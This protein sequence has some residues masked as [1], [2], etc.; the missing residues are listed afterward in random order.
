[1]GQQMSMDDPRRVLVVD[2]HVGVR[3]GIASLI[4]GEHPRLLTV[5][6][7]ATPERRCD[8]PSNSSR[9]WWCSTSTSPARTDW[10]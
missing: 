1:M 6:T 4:D 9:T 5:A 3:L 7:A 8:A 10:R 2:D